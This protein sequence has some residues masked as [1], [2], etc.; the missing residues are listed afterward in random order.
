MV[1][2]RGPSSPVP[3]AN[4]SSQP[5]HSETSLSSPATSSSLPSSSTVSGLSDSGTLSLPLLDGEMMDSP[6]AD[7]SVG[8]SFSLVADNSVWR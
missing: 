7:L 3:F 2:S 5:S 1:S 4:A 6:Q 8:L